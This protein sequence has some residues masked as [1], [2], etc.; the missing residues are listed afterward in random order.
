M[1]KKKKGGLLD[2]QRRILAY[3]GGSPGT[4]RIRREIADGAQCH[5][6]GLTAWVGSPDD[7]IRTRNDRRYCKSLATP[8]YVRQAVN[9]DAKGEYLH[10]ITEAGRKALE[11]EAQP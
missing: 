6:H 4:P 10:E 11:T 9:P 5:Q 8:G 7:S 3:L 2:T 1:A